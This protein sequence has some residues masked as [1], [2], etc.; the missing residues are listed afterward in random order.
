MQPVSTSSSEHSSY[1]A[2][3]AMY[4]DYPLYVT[5]MTDL[6][7]FDTRLVSTLK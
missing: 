2:A 6:G 3:A 7:I 4:A 1:P 5:G